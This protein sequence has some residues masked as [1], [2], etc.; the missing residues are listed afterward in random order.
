MN[1]LL[2]NKTLAGKL[3]KE[4]V[5]K[6][7]RSSGKG[8]QNVNKV[9]T[10]VIL[11]FNVDKSSTLSNENK[12]IIKQKL[13]K[14]IS[15]KGTLQIT[16]SEERTQYMNKKEAIKKFL[17]LIDGSLKKQKARIATVKDKSSENN[18]LDEKTHISE[19]KVLRKKII[20]N[21]E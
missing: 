11:I 7:T 9:S 1:R 10:K 15:S 13:N 19:K 17:N 18:R 5:F 14:K 20:L 12:A 6:S 2:I 16:A 3:L 21:E 4:L 8:G